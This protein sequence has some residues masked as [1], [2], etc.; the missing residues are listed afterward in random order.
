MFIFVIQQRNLFCPGRQKRFLLWWEELDSNRRSLSAADLCGDGSVPLRADHAEHEVVGIQF[1]LHDHGENAGAAAG[2]QRDAPVVLLHGL[3]LAAAVYVPEHDVGEP[4][5][6]CLEAGSRVFEIRQGRILYAAVKLHVGDDVELCGHFSLGDPVF[7]G[8]SQDQVEDRLQVGVGAFIEAPTVAH[9][10]NQVPSPDLH[11]PGVHGE[12]EEMVVK[13]A[14]V[15]LGEVDCQGL[16]DRSG[17]RRAAP[18]HG[19][20]AVRHHEGVLVRGEVLQRLPGDVQT[21]ALLLG[22]FVGALHQLIGQEGAGVEFRLAQVYPIQEGPVAVSVIAQEGLAIFEHGLGGLLGVI[23]GVIP[24]SEIVLDDADASPQGGQG[25]AVVPFGQTE[26]TGDEPGFRHRLPAGGIGGGQP[27][28][29]QGYVALS[30]QGGKVLPELPAQQLQGLFAAGGVQQDEDVVPA[31]VLGDVGQVLHE[32]ALLV[33]GKPGEDA[34][35]HPALSQ[36][37]PHV[38]GKEED[39]HGQVRVL[40]VRLEKTRADLLIVGMAQGADGGEQVQAGISAGAAGDGS[41][42]GIGLV[43][44]ILQHFQHGIALLFKRRKI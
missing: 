30:G 12:G 31:A 28:S 32:G 4:V 15:A 6:G 37:A 1:A 38:P 35:E 16:G 34:P 24:L 10:L 7:H 43:C 29:Q 33:G 36:T 27:L 22:A 42:F 3:L 5:A 25:L 21:A 19:A 40:R 18:V 39:L 20:G 41:V 23:E 44:G 2:D 17:H 14:V 13:G 9:L 26:G 8:S 11:Q